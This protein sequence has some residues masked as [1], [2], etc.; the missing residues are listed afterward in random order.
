MF[1]MESVNEM[2]EHLDESALESMLLEVDSKGGMSEAEAATHEVRIAHESIREGYAFENSPVLGDLDKLPAAPGEG[3]VLSAA[4]LQYHRGEIS[5]FLEKAFSHLGARS[6]HQKGECE[7]S[8]KVSEDE[9][10]H[11]WRLIK[12]DGIHGLAGGPPRDVFRNL[13][14]NRR[15]A[16][17]TYRS[18]LSSNV[19]GSQPA[20][21]TL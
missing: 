6:H 14:K 4:Q 1:A 16:V 17:R 5:S 9:F 12:R 11:L 3:E 8:A 18:I 19:D 20:T 7:R 15:R 13:L 21:T 2:L 10:L